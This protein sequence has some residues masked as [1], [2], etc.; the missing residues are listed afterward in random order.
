[1]FWS[2]RHSGG[3]DDFVEPEEHSLPAPLLTAIF[4]AVLGLHAVFPALV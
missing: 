4:L 2:G 3:F 1:L